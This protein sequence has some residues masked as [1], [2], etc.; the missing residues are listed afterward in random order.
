[1]TTDNS[2]SVMQSTADVQKRVYENKVNH[3]FNTT[4][5][6]KEFCLLYGEVA[7]AF[8]AWK[9]DDGLNLE[10]ADVAIYLLGIAEI[11]GIDLGEAIDKKMTINE[12]RIYKNKQ[13]QV[14]EEKREKKDEFIDA[15]EDYDAWLATLSPE[16]RDHFMDGIK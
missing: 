7:E 9:K 3:G 10:L 15:A 12:G 11:N 13:K 6:P 4:D 8:D 16:M 1:M 14:Q 2:K 5:V